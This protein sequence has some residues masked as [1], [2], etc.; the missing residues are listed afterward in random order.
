MNGDTHAGCC[1]QPFFNIFFPFFSPG[2]VTCAL[3]L[4]YITILTCLQ[5]LFPCVTGNA[6]KAFTWD[7]ICVSFCTVPAATCPLLLF[8]FSCSYSKVYL[9]LIFLI[10]FSYPLPSLSLVLGRSHSLPFHP[11]FHYLVGFHLTLSI[12]LQA[13]IH[14]AD[15]KTSPNN[16]WKYSFGIYVLGTSDLEKFQTCFTFKFLTSL[17]HLILLTE[18]KWAIC[19]NSRNLLW[20]FSLYFQLILNRDLLWS[21]CP[22]SYSIFRF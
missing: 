9:G 14:P 15:L 6:D 8:A 19:F 18:F 16:Y 20:S 22:W 12:Y 4:G 10:I 21:F 1:L 11:I 17:I 3:P 13:V 5:S 7:H 2:L